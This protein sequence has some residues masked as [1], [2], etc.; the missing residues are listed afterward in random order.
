MGS[1]KQH[2]TKE[3]RDELNN[4][5]KMNCKECGHSIPEPVRSTTGLLKVYCNNEC[6]LKYRKRQI[7]NRYY[8]HGE[9]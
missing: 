6:R 3:Q 7:A 2:I 8:P 1:I 5:D 4:Q 9:S